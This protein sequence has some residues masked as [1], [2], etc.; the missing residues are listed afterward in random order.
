[1][2]VKSILYNTDGTVNVDLVSKVIR[3]KAYRKYKYKNVEVFTQFNAITGGN[4]TFYVKTDNASSNPTLTASLGAIP[5][6]NMQ[7][8]T[9]ENDGAYFISGNPAGRHSGGSND[10]NAIISEYYVTESWSDGGSF[11]MNDPFRVYD[12]NGNI[13]WS[14]GTISDAVVFATKLRF[15]ALNQVQTFTSSKNRRLFIN[16]NTAFN[17]GTW[18][19]ESVSSVSGIIARWTNGG[20]TLSINY[21]GYYE[22][23]I[24]AALSR[25]GYLDVEIFEILGI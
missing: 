11:A 1:M 3:W 2:P 16:M 6:R 5:T 19:G 10:L 24:N 12:Q 22:G 20:K 23:D 7:L 15:T 25:R 13:L 21:Y 18:D 4:M 14:A 17:S 8:L 9:C